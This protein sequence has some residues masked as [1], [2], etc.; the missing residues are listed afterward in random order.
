MLTVDFDRFPVGSG[1]LVLDMGCGAGRHAFELARRGAD[2]VALDMDAD[3]LSGVSDM[4]AAMRIEHEIPQGS[5]TAAVRGNAYTLPFPDATFDR[6]VAAEVLEHLPEDT[7]AM[8]ELTRVLKPGGIIA[9]SVPRWGPE[10]VCWALSDEYHEV[11]GGHVRIYKGSQL[12]E[13][14]TS[15]GLVQLSEHHAHSLHAPYWWLKCAV[16]VDNAENRLVDTYHRILVWDMMKAPRLTRVTERI[17]NPLI[18]KS[19]VVYL[20][21][22]ERAHVTV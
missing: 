20:T 3:E 17:L 16:G 13:R 22:P 11:E 7:L 6:I 1:D 10:R 19:L 15:T 18:G 8:A 4:L 2:V 14:L 5:V 12:S 9:V 21:K